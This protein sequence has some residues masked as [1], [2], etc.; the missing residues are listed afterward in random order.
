MLSE[1]LPQQPAFRLPRPHPQAHN[2]R[3]NKAAPGAT[4]GRL[5]VITLGS[6][7]H[8]CFNCPRSVAPAMERSKR[9]DAHYGRCR[10]FFFTKPIKAAL[11]LSGA[12][13]LSSAWLNWSI[14]AP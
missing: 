8:P 1:R 3:R 11:R 10:T 5:C 2:H 9:H 12:K 4:L 6:L 13:P 7:E 14:I